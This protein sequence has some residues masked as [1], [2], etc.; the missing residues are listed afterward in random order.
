[1]TTIIKRDTQVYCT[2]KNMF[3]NK[4]KLVEI[5]ADNCM[6]KYKLSHYSDRTEKYHTVDLD[7]PVMKARLRYMRDYLPDILMEQLNDGTLYLKLLRLN[8]KVEKAVDRQV[9][10]WQDTNTEYLAASGD[11]F[12]QFAISE[13]MR[14]EAERMM[15]DAMVYV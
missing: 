3:V 10:L 11:F 4:W 12:R 6:R 8:D 2:Y 7:T 1:M 13:R 14:I 15:Y 5:K 9:M